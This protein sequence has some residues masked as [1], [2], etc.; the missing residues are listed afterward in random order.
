[1]GMNRYSVTV[2]FERH[3]YY[4]QTECWQGYARNMSIAMR[5]A[6]KDVLARRGVKRLRHA[7]ILFEIER[8]KP[9][10]IVKETC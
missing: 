2:K 7:R 10:K 1:M 9:E 8:I 5:K 4:N 3:R 6:T